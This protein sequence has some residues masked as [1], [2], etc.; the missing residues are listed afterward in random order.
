MVDAN[1]HGDISEKFI[2]ARVLLPLNAAIQ[3]S[4][5]LV[6]ETT[7]EEV[8][9]SLRYERLPNFCLFCGLIGHREMQCFIPDAEKKIRYSTEL[10]V[11]PVIQGDA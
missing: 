6:D 9:T 3:K 5:S 7:G 11:P 1:S 4:I 8:E 2:R 10:S